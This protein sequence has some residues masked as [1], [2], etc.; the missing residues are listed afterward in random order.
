MR[1]RV[2]MLRQQAA[3][4]PRQRLQ[5]ALRSRG[6]TYRSAATFMPAHFTRLHKVV[7]GESDPSLALAV[8]IERE[9]GVA[10]EEWP[11]LREPIVEL[12]RLRAERQVA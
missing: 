6:L 11:S 3:E 10:V 12:L 5:R 7:K 8:A 1:Y 9:F 4:Q 2:G